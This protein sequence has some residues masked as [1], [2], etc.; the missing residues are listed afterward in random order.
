MNLNKVEAAQRLAAQQQEIKNDL[1]Y[2]VNLIA[3]AD[4]SAEAREI[5]EK[6]TERGEQ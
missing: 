2:L 6:Y 5:V 1:Y 3:D 4:I